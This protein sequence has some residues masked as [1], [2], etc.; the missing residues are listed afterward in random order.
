MFIFNWMN[1]LVCICSLELGDEMANS[2][3][4]LTAEQKRKQ[5]KTI[6]IDEGPRLKVLGAEATL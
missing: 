2:G 1:K 5:K 3:C 6:T 4:K